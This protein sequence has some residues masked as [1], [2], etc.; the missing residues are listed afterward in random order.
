MVFLIYEY[1][2]LPYLMVLQVCVDISRMEFNNIHAQRYIFQSPARANIN[3]TKT[4]QN[5]INVKV[6]PLKL[7]YYQTFFEI[8]RN[9]HS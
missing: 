5:T 1:T 7:F 4:Q 8:W 6:I 2:Y 9:E 3:M